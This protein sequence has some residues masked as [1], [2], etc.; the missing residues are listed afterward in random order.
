MQINKIERDPETK[1]GDRKPKLQKKPKNFTRKYSRYCEIYVEQV[2][3]KSESFLN[4][5]S[6]AK[7]THFRICK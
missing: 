2:P 1:T 7:G 3:A 5:T 6:Q 4:L